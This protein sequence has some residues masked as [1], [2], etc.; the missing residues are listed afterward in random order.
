MRLNVNDICLN[1]NIKLD[2]HTHAMWWDAL[3]YIKRTSRARS[4]RD[5]HKQM[6]S[7]GRNDEHFAIWRYLSDSYKG[8][9]GAAAADE[10]PF[11]LFDSLFAYV[12][13]FFLVVQDQEKNNQIVWRANRARRQR[14]VVI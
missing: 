4:A 1:L 11:A 2:M 9:S 6:C 3:I 12:C 13:V 8:D 14:T 5:V 10:N 7:L